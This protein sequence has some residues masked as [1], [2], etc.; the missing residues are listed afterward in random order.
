MQPSASRLH[1]M[2]AHHQFEGITVHDEEKSL[3]FSPA[4][5]AGENVLAALIRRVDR[6]D[7]SY[8]R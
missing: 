2:V 5:G 4:H 1:N 8:R 7:P 6:I 3:Q